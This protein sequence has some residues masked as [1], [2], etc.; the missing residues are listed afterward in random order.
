MVPKHRT[1]PLVGVFSLAFL[2]ILLGTFTIRRIRTR[3]HTPYY[4][5][6]SKQRIGR[7]NKKIQVSSEYDTWGVITTINDEVNEAVTK[8]VSRGNVGL[9]IVGDLVTDHKVW[10]HFESLHRNVVYLPPAQQKELPFE[11]IKK[12]PWNHFGR[13]NVGF[14]YAVYLGAKHVYDFD[15]DNHLIESFN[16]DD[17]L[18][19]MTWHTVETSHH[20]WNPYP[21]FE[22]TADNTASTVE[23]SAP[24]FIWPRGFPLQFIKDENTTNVAVTPAPR[25]D[26]VSMENLAVVQFLANHDPDVDAIYRM[27][28][29]LPITFKRNDAAVIMPRGSFAPWNAQAT[30]VAEAGYFGLLLPVTVSWRVTDIWRSYITMRLLWETDENLAFTSALVTQYRNPHSYQKDLELEEDLYYKADDVLTTLSLWTSDRFKT[31]DGAYLDLVSLMVQHGHFE[32][33]D[34]DLAQAWVKDLK[35]LGYTWPKITHRLDSFVPRKRPIVDGRKHVLADNSL[36]PPDVEPNATAK[37]EPSVSR[38]QVVWIGQGPAANATKWLSFARSVPLATLF[39]HSYDADCDGCI[40]AKGTTYATGRNMLFRQA[41][42]KVKDAKY[43]VF[44]DYD[45]IMKCN[46][47]S[48]EAECWRLFHNMLSDPNT[49]HPFIAPKTWWD[50]AGEATNYVTCVD[51][52]LSAYRYDYVHMI[53]PLPIKNMEKGWNFNCH[54][55]WH[56][57]ERCFP[58]A[59]LSDSRW[60]VENPAHAPYPQLYRDYQYIIGILEH[61]YKELGPW[62][63]KHELHHQCSKSNHTPKHTEFWPK[64]NAVFQQRFREWIDRSGQWNGQL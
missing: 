61:D 22:P 14:L 47:S 4:M 57:V 28:A 64:C 38:K 9:V 27:T 50:P 36:F 42:E 39:Y 52:A 13:K 8:F 33:L 41:L 26:T 29:P 44:F 15:D 46:D 59:Y 10:E 40:Y 45:L 60:R 2:S 7:E 6:K 20:L 53:Y 31:L 35:S 51:N 48:N 43:F 58:D 3:E 62:D 55:Q 21:F 19:G 1:F 32:Q 54:V 56:L 5:G 16:F 17:P 30:L 23:I 18:S 24:A 12:H 11:L 37:P 34:L 49:M 63:P 25:S